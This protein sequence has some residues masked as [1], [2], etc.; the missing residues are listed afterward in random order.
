MRW[1]HVTIVGNLGATEQVAHTLNFR[2]NPA[3]VDQDAAALTTFAGQVRDHFVAFLNT[4]PAQANIPVIKWLSPDLVYKEVRAAYLEQTVPASVTTE[5]GK[6]GPRK[7]FHYPR[8]AYLVPTQYAQFAGNGVAGQGTDPA[9]PYEVAMAITHTTG[10]RGPR[11]RGRVFLGGLT[12]GLIAPGGMFQAQWVEAIGNA[13]GVRMVNGLNTD[14][15]NRLH[16]VSRAYAS[17]VG[18]NGVSV[19]HVP[20][21]QRRRRRSQL[22][23]AKSVWTPATG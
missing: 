15:G 13:W 5:Q 8:P 23:A 6:R 11:N 19:G 18:V 17:S 2:T 22:E 14:T 20:D 1:I 9:L 12:S 21:S 16:V 7:V 3:D 4:A 10:L